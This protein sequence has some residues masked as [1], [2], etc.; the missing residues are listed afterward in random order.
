VFFPGGQPIVELVAIVGEYLWC[1]PRSIGVR[2]VDSTGTSGDVG[3]CG[4][5][6]GDAGDCGY[7]EQRW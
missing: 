4:S 3:R 2:P 7:G 6:E 1:D 5:G